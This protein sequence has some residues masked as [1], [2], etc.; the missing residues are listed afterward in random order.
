MFLAV[1]RER[2]GDVVVAELRGWIDD[3]G[4]S[5]FWDAV[6][7]KFFDLDLGEADRLSGRDFRFMQ[8]L[9]PGTPIHV[10][11]L[12]DE[13]Q[14]VI[15]RPHA[16][17]EP[18]AGMLTAIGFRNHGYIDIF[19]AGLCLDAFIDDVDVVRRA[20]HR[21]V[22]LAEE[23]VAGDRGIIANTALA[24]FTMIEGAVVHDAEQPL[25]AFQAEALGVTDGDT[26]VTYSFEAPRD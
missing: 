24:D 2:F 13:A 11:L 16:G 14:V 3:D 20:T 22:R 26:V 10:D 25:T 21:T 7:S 17:S 19:D 5:P 1:H 6:G 15:G 12:P 8:D 23:P 18:A 9:L 4:H